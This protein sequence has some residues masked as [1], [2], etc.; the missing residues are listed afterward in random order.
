MDTFDPA[1]HAI[2]ALIMILENMT[3]LQKDLAK[4]SQ[5]RSDSPSRQK[6]TSLDTK[7]SSSQQTIHLF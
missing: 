4:V 3:L 2:R 5:R 6:Y 1:L 7:G